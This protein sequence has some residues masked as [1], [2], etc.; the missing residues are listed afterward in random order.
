MGEVGRRREQGREHT[1]LLSYR[2][3]RISCDM[4]GKDGAGSV[5]SLSFLLQS[6]TELN[7]ETIADEK[8]R[9]GKVGTGEGTTSK[10][11]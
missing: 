10:F 1:E 8:E 7:P 5:S 11:F 6:K 9:E 3:S 2:I 4:K